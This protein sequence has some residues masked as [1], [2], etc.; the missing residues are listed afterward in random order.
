MKDGRQKTEDGSRCLGLGSFETIYHVLMLILDPWKGWVAW[1]RRLSSSESYCKVTDTS[2]VY[3]AFFAAN[4]IQSR[5]DV[6]GD[7]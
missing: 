3:R 6:C 5:M 1:A 2:E 7:E 4:D